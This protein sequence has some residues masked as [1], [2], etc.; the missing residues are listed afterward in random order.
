M[1]LSPSHEIP[2]VLEVLVP[3]TGGKDPVYVSQEVTFY[4]ITARPPPP[5]WG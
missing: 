5:F 4:G 2:R 1:L 3:G